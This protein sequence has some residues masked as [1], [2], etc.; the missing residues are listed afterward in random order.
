MVA[1]YVFESGCGRVSA[2]LPV[3]LADKRSPE[4][5]LGLFYEAE[6]RGLLGTVFE[7]T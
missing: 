3:D 6:K 1:E 7:A 5:L 4:E 2:K